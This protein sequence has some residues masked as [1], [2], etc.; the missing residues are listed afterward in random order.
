MVSKT[1]WTLDAKVKVF[2]AGPLDFAESQGLCR[3]LSQESSHRVVGLGTTR[4]WK[5]ELWFSRGV[6]CCY[7]TFVV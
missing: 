4:L 6:F 7:S 2:S 5:S 3:E 1:E